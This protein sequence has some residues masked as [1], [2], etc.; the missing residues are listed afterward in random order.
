MHDRK[1][2]KAFL[3]GLKED[4]KGDIENMKSSRRFYEM[5]LNGL[6][7]FLKWEVV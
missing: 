4:L 7:S 1:E 2:E 5:V 6:N 3:K